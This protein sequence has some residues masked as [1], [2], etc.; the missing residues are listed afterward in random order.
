[1]SPDSPQQ[2]AIKIIDRLLRCEVDIQ[3]DTPYAIDIVTRTLQ[4]QENLVEIHRMR[5][6]DQAMIVTYDLFGRE[7]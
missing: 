3:N 4:H 5:Q 6:V 7:K 2:L 1:M